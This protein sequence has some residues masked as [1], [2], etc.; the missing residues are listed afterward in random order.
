MRHA[1]HRPVRRFE[2]RWI[3]A[4]EAERAE[5]THG[6]QTAE[7]LVGPSRPS[8]RQRRRQGAPPSMMRCCSVC[9]FIVA[10]P[11]APPWVIFSSAAA[12]SE[13]QGLAAAE[14]LAGGGGSHAAI[15][16]ADATTAVATTLLRAAPAS[17]AASE[18]ASFHAAH[19]RA[20]L[21]TFPHLFCHN[22]RA[23]GAEALRFAARLMGERG[24]A[25]CLQIR[26]AGIVSQLTPRNSHGN[27][28]AQVLVY[29]HTRPVSHTL[30]WTDASSTQLQAETHAHA[31]R[32][33]SPRVAAAVLLMQQ[34]PG[35][36]A[37]FVLADEFPYI[38]SV[39]MAA[40]GPAKAGSAASDD[41]L[42][43]QLSAMRFRI[44]CAPTRAT[45]PVAT[46][47]S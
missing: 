5:G 17:T 26:R 41:R 18:L 38:L 6:R 32:R 23:A 16:G 28:H 43:G 13:P 47:P 44:V 45:R 31:C 19:G 27:V 30:S 15:N 7:E 10:V 22:Q 40:A 21:R 34:A 20:V 42:A 9:A 29:T 14:A 24:R 35:V 33:M 3:A 37:S 1:P 46:D 11:V 39:A 4:G 36:P 2:R 12:A 8:I 25:A